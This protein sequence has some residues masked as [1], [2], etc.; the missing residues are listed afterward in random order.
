MPVPS[1]DIR[2]ASHCGTRPPCNGRSA[3]PERFINTKTKAGLTSARF[4]PLGRRFARCGAFGP[5]FD[6]CF[7][8]C[9][10]EHAILI[11]KIDAVYVDGLRKSKGTKD[12]SGSKI[13]EVNGPFIGFRLVLVIG[14]DE[15]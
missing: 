11:L 12:R 2:S 14:L 9:H 5:R 4:L 10:A 6:A 15:H 3:V 8:R 7:C 13:P 1:L